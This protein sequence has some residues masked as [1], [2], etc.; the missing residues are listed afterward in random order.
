[1]S[2]R[3]GTY[4]WRLIYQVLEPFPVVRVVVPTKDPVGSVHVF[5][6]LQQ[7][8]SLSRLVRQAAKEQPLE[9]DVYGLIISQPPAV[10]IKRLYCIPVHV[11]EHGDPIW[12]QA[13]IGAIHRAKR[14]WGVWW[15]IARNQ[16][17]QD[18]CIQLM[19]AS[20]AFWGS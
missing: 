3:V 12:H 19:L 5:V 6:Q 14:G 20:I 1:M 18:L 8:R 11:T 4:F 16:V 7:G 10:G 15:V 2:H 9:L 13:G 17:V